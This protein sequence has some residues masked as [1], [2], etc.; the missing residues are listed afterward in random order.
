MAGAPG[1]R[2]RLS[3][4]DGLTDCNEFTA[5]RGCTQLGRDVWLAQHQHGPPAEDDRT[6]YIPHR[7]HNGDIEAI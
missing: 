2:R 5:D 1:R 6:S 3:Y 7:Q 4:T